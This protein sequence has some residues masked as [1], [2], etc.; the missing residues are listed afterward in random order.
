MDKETKMYVSENW[1]KDERLDL[2]DLICGADDIYE[3]E[4]NDLVDKLYLISRI[5]GSPAHNLEL[6][7][8][9]FS[10][11]ILNTEV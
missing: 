7:R 9:S 10:Q 1:T 4:R 11:Y 2:I 6:N 8:M 5:I 3:L